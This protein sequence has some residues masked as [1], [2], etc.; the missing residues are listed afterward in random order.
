MFWSHYE[1]FARANPNSPF[2]NANT[3][4][5]QRDLP[6]GGNPTYNQDEDNDSTK[7]VRE[8]MEKLPMKLKNG[9][10]VTVIGHI[11]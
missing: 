5:R 7:M 9:D 10:S 1:I 8:K 4:V 2:P 11:V 6:L 3:G